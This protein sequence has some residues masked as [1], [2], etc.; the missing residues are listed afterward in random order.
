MN[1]KRV[2]GRGRPHKYSDNFKGEVVQEVLGGE[3]TK[4]EAKRNRAC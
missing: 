2:N 4:A 3:I 1:N